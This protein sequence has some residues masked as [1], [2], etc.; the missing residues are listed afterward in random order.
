M[1]VQLLVSCV[2]AKVDELIAKMQ[3]SSDAIIVNQCNQYAYEEREINGRQIRIF[4]MKERG[5][6]LSRNHA[7]LRASTSYALLSD[8]D[9][10]YVEDYESLIIDEFGKH[11]DADMLLFQ[12]DVESERRTYTNADY[13][14]VNRFNCGRYPAFCMAFRTEKMHEVGVTFSI[15]FGG[16]A[17]YSNGEDSLFIRSCIKKGMKVYKT[18]VRIG[19]E[20]PRPSTWFHGYDEKFFYDRGVLFYHLYGCMAPL[21]GLRFILAKRKEMCKEIKW[22][23]A[24]ML[25]LAG[26]KRG[27]LCS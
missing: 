9:I 20:V 25:V 7:L 14:R 27:N 11:L 15:L 23:K 4:H 19:R 13:G 22:K 16:G 17:M 6:G 18:P 12:V 1:A 2:N 3:I 5:V 26:I 10:E 8:E 24:L 21:W